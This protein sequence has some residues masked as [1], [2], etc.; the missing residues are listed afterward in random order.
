[1]KIQLFSSCTDKSINGVPFF[2]PWCIRARPDLHERL[3]LKI[4]SCKTSPPIAT[5][6]KHLQMSSDACGIAFYSEESGIV[7]FISNKHGGLTIMMLKRHFVVPRVEPYPQAAHSN[8]Q[9]LTDKLLLTSLYV[10][11]SLPFSPAALSSALFFL[12]IL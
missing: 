2:S 11:L 4:T 9:F 10:L 8:W 3:P 6:W 7:E 1:M 12:V 5:Q